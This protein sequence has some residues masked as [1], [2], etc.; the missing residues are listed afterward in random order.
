M[1]HACLATPVGAIPDVIKDGE[2]GFIMENNSQ[3]CVAENVIRV[4]EHLNID[5]I[6][7]NARL[8][9]E[10]EFSYEAAVERYRTIMEEL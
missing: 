8:L 9:V 7:K 2:T 5:I 6:V 4:L 10:R 3:E 1:W